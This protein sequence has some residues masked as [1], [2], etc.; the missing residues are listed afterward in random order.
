MALERF[1]QFASLVFVPHW[2]TAP[3]NADAPAN[4]LRLIKTL[5][6]YR[7]IDVQLAEACLQTMHRHLWYLCEETVVLTL[8][9]PQSS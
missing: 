2:L 3:I 9:Q 7:E 1:T 6:Q 5:I 8:V 4:D